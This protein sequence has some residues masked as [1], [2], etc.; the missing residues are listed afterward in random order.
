MSTVEDSG[1]IDWMSCGDGCIQLVIV[2]PLEWSDVHTHL[3]ALQRKLDRYLDFVE[4][5]EIFERARKKW[6]HETGPGTPIKISI[7]GRLPLPD[8]PQRFLKHAQGIA[9][10]LGVE[11]LHEVRE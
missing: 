10:E 1:V 9:A 4:S 3:H 11:L 5:G 7:I 2:D 6:G 8:E